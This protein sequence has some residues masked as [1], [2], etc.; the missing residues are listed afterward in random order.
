M[1]KSIY[2]PSI[3]RFLS[4]IESIAMLLDDNLTE[5]EALEAP[6]NIS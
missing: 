4:R 1:I 2:F 6:T 5:M 3:L